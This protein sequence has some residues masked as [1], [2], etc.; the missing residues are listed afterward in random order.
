MRSKWLDSD[1][2][3]L[4][5]RI[6]CVFHSSVCGPHVIRPWPEKRVLV[7]AQL[8]RVFPERVVLSRADLEC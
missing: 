1:V 8:E 3:R 4:K 2:P 7:R 5:G 6:G